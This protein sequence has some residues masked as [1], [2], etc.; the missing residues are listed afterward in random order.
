MEQSPSWEANRFTA[1]QEIPRIYRTQRFITA[2]TNACH[3]SLSWANSIQPIPPHPTS[4]RSILILFSH[5][6]LD[7]LSGLFPP[8]F[9]TKTLYTPLPSPIR[10]TC[11][12]HLI[13]FDF[14][15]RKTLGEQYRP[16]S[17]SLCSFLHSPC[18]IPLRPKY[19]PQ[20]PILKHPQPMLLPHC[21]W[22]RFTSIQNNRQ[23]YS[24]AYLNLKIFG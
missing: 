21:Q 12:A 11:P 16:S 15:T 23:N 10:A 4:W 14:I 5:L 17:S 1:S 18:Y 13:L 9:P 7:L 6:R 19:S 22:P 24:S 2:F 8:G 20:H 3:L